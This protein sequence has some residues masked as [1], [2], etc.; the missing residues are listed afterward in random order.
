[1]TSTSTGQW[2]LWI[3]LFTTNRCLCYSGCLF[4]KGGG[5]REEREGEIGR[6]GEEGERESWSDLVCLFLA[7]VVV[8]VKCL[9]TSSFWGPY[10]LLTIFGSEVCFTWLPTML[11]TPTNYRRKN[12]ALSN[13]CIPLSAIR[14]VQ[15]RSYSPEPG[16]E[17]SSSGLSSTHCN[18]F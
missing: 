10:D 3:V 13:T 7:D 18:Y 11:A 5:R 16:L 12:T 2:V 8:C 4:E 14:R 6:E 17:G 9:I 15:R 1:M